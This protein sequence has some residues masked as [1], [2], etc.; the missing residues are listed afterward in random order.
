MAHGDFVWCDLSSRRIA[1]AQ[2]FYNRLFQWQYQTLQAGD[3]SDYLIASAGNQANAGLYV[4]PQEFQDMGMP[5]FWMSY[6]AVSSAEQAVSDAARLGG[7]VEMGPRDWG[8]GSRIALIRDPL[9]AGFT[10]VEG[11]TFL[12]RNSKPSHGSIGWNA[13]YVSNAASVIPFYEQ[14]FG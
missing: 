5:C 9:G 10:V 4:M 14:L 8:D 3:G 1:V 2:Q 6:I 12:L 11:S 7:K 13:L